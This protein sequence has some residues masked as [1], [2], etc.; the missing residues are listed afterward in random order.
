MS[1]WY[2]QDGKTEYTI[3]GAN[4]NER[5]TTLRD[6]RKHNYV[7]SV[8]TILQVCAK[9]QLEIW[10]QNQILE[11]CINYAPP[12]QVH[13]NIEYPEWAND[14]KKWKAII[15]EQSQKVGKES[16]RLGSEIHDSLENYFTGKQAN[17]QEFV[18][19]VIERLLQE[20]GVQHWVPEKAFGHS[21]GF[22]GKVDVHA[23]GYIIDFKTK[24]ESA[25]FD[26][27]LGYDEHLMQLAAYRLGLDLPKARCY[28]LFISTAKPGLLQLKEWT[29]PELEKGLAMFKALLKYWQLV[30]NYDSSFVGV[31]A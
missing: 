17:N 11:A 29:E 21:L 20:I 6:A 12:R 16:A 8:T 3:I 14:V 23:S 22:G 30:N 18:A 2:R 1:H 19:P 25:N 5:A 24:T 28:N 26:K 4:G 15:L 31:K 9:P 13:G 27:D 10:K 7:P